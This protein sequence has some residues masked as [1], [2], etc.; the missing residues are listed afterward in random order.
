MTEKQEKAIAELRNYI[1]ESGLEVLKEREINY[2]LQ[3]KITNGTA[4]C[5]VNIYT[6]G[7]VT[8]GGKKSD[9]K[10]KIEEWK[11][12]QQAGLLDAAQRQEQ[13]RAEN[14]ASKYVVSLAKVDKIRN[15]IAGFSESIAWYEGDDDSS[16]I[17]RAELHADGHKV[18]VTQYRTG[19]LL[20]QGRVCPLFD[21]L[22]ERLDHKL[23]QSIPERAARYVPEETREEALEVMKQPERE[24]AALAWIYQKIGEDAYD[25]LY[26]HDQETLL[27]A[28]ML[29]QAAGEFALELSDY[30]VLVMPFARAYEG[31][32]LKL[33]CQIGLADEDAIKKDGRAIQIGKWLRD[34]EHIIVD[35]R[36]HGHIARDLDTAWSGCRNLLLH[37][38]P[39]R[40]V[41][42]QNWEKADREIG[43]V[44]RSIERGHKHFIENP[45]DL[46]FP[47]KKSQESAEKPK[48]A[49]KKKTDKVRGIDEGSLLSRIREAGHKVEHYDDPESHTK[50]CVVTEGWKIF[51][52]RDPGDLLIVK[53]KDREGFLSWYHSEGSDKAS[54]DEGLIAHIGVDEAGK[55]DYFGP[56]VVGAVYVTPD[57]AL[58]LV[59]LGVRDSKSLSDSKISDLALEIQEI[60][61]HTVIILQPPEYNEAYQKKPNL[62]QLLADLHVEAIEDLVAE[63]GCEQ[64]VDDQFAAEHVLEDALKVHELKVDL[65]QRTGGESDVAV[66]AAS[67]LAR[68]AFVAAIEDY[69]AK[70]G[71]EIPLGSSSPHVVRIGRIVAHR[72]GPDALARIA[73]LNFKTTRKILPDS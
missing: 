65:E 20:V 51:C 46:K 50:W 30:S 8:V 70:S 40:D 23:S 5:P 55:G 1:S 2:G 17:Y 56:L 53:G 37:S 57:T 13:G 63:T 61:P 7:K 15:W 28:T 38:D 73:K 39:G 42:M 32:L 33:F 11:N 64:V 16:Q 72:W 60:C 21:D 9:L 48:P 49:L 44:I 68:E 26:E 66:A 41:R 22:C 18:V 69:R 6:S 12:L 62:N 54:M 36:R 24:K 35:K 47:E 25:F 14:R 3:I 43:V 71:L 29:L 19:T 4:V 52:P 45:I 34:L 59:R 67:I 58:S 10:A 27:S 31:F